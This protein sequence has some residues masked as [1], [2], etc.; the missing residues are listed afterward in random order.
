MNA[1]FKMHNAQFEEK[2]FI[3][4]Q[5]WCKGEQLSQKLRHVNCWNIVKRIEMMNDKE[6]W[7]LALDVGRILLEHLQAAT[8]RDDCLITYGDVAKKLPY[9]FNP[10]NLDSPLY[11]LSSLCKELGLPLISTAVVNQDSLMP[12]LGYYG[13]FFPGVRTENQRIDTFTLEIN[14]V[15]QCKD[16]SPLARA[17]GL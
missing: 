15:W 12:G 2:T 16:W 14:R 8:T 3:E 11:E 6:F 13:A 10:R 9:E 4:S 7:G 17:L 1:S 5:A